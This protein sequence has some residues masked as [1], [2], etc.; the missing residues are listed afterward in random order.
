MTV[1]T[2]KQKGK[3]QENDDKF[4]KKPLFIGRTGDNFVE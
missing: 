4:W 3:Q 1:D 2:N